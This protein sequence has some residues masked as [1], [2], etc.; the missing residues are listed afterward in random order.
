MRIS[1]IDSDDVRAIRSVYLKTVPATEE[2]PEHP[3]LQVDYW[4]AASYP[5]R[6]ALLSFTTVFVAQRDLVVE[7]FDAIVGT[8]RWPRP[9][10]STPADPAGSATTDATA[11]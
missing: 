4:I 2:V 3:M 11:K 1:R 6:V 7:L 5:A 9:R 10:S 8:T